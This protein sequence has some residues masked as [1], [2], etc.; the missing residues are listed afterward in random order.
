MK[1]MFL[2]PHISDGGAERILSEL[3]QNLS[4][5][6]QVLV[7]FEEKAGYPFKGRL[8]SLDMPIERG[9]VLKRARGLIRRAWKLRRI[10]REERPD[11]VVSF[12]GEA[13]ILNSL[14]AP[15]PIVT[16]HNHLSSLAELTRAGAAGKLAKIRLWFEELAAEALIRSLYRRA[17]VVAVSEIIR[18]EM[19]ERFRV[20]E[21]QV[22]VIP[23]AINTGEIRAKA[24]EPAAC[25][26][27]PG[28]PVIVTAGRLTL[29][30][31]Q[32]RLI[33]AF[34]EVRKTVP[35]QLAILGTGELESEL[36]SL[37][38]SLGVE[39]D[40]YFLGWQEN[41]WKFM[42]RADVF[43]LP[44]IS[45]GFGLVILEA[46][47][48]GVPVIATDCPGAAREILFPEYGVLVPPLDLLTKN[49]DQLSGAILRMLQDGEARQRYVTAG[50]ERVRHF[51][52]PAFVEKYQRL[53]EKTA[54][55]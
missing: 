5:T 6:E 31:G 34:A 21:R 43:V 1:V 39:A 23:N 48:C 11:T 51:E 38:R 37:A 45:E 26:W 2:I 41:P 12:M 4:V 14:L 3:S 53:I 50:F 7:V 22:V 36:K 20:P 49:V 13:N 25:P 9:S 18:K 46:M 16:V 19:I 28:I 10:L 55:M 35:C 47:A 52:Y 30:K 54:G 29:Q 15:N 32:W 44:S 40:V 17:R 27:K 42:A 8:L 24:S 33:R